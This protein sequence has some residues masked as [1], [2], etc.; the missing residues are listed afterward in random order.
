MKKPA[1]PFFSVIIATYDRASLIGRALKSLVM[2]TELDWE[3]IIIDDGSTDNTVDQLRGYIKTNGKIRYYYYTHKGMVFAKNTGIRHARGEFITFLDSDDEYD[4][5]HLEIKRRILKNDPSLQF[6]YGRTK[7]IGQ[8]YV[9]DRFDTSRL[10]HLDQCV[11]SGN[12]VFESQALQKLEGFR[13]LKFGTD[14]DLFDR[15]VASGLHMTEVK[16]RTYIY[17]HETLDSNTNR[18][19]MHMV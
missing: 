1:K 10:I 15:A 13:N 12:F 3:A 14:A 11:A 19:M 7:I 18:L 9:P 8:P 6:L 17:H 4:V 16:Q 2:Q 5:V